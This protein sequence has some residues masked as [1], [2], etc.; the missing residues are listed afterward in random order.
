MEENQSKRTTKEVYVELLNLVQDSVD[1]IK[2]FH[3]KKYHISGKRIRKMTK[4]VMLLAK[5]L[6][7]TTT[8]K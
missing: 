6:K 2:L 7:N 3:E 5:E 4:Q 8:N 1:E